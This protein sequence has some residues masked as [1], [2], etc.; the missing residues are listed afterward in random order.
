MERTVQKTSAILLGI[1]IGVVILAVFY[2]YAVYNIIEELMDI[3]GR[4]KA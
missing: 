3:N 2:G 4:Q 1:T